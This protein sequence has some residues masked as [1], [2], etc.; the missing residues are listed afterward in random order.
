MQNIKSYILYI[1]YSLVSFTGYIKHLTYS[2][3]LPWCSAHLLDT[4]MLAKS[5]SV[6][7]QTEHLRYLEGSTLHVP[8]QLHYLLLNPRSRLFSSAF[9][10]ECHI[11][12]PATT[13]PVGATCSCKR[14]Q[15][16]IFSREVYHFKSA[17]QL[18]W[19][20]FLKHANKTP[21]TWKQSTC[22]IGTQPRQCKLSLPITLPSQ[23]LLCRRL[24]LKSAGR[25]ADMNTPQPASVRFFTFLQ[26]A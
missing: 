26:L 6:L 14:V 2:S 5:G 18:H 22:E 11:Q 9:S 10:Q 7:V 19:C 8:L 20:N 16:H 23:L 15:G 25:L 24:P 1:Y 21:L 17:L 3:V 12:N 4:F 13:I